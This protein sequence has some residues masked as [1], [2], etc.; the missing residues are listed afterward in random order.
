MKI[1]QSRLP[2]ALKDCSLLELD[3]IRYLL[4]RASHVDVIFRDQV[5]KSF[6][7]VFTVRYNIVLRLG[8]LGQVHVV[9]VWGIDLHKINYQ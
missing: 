8:V 9:T 2:P 7:K 1:N 5:L 4:V 3:I 6:V